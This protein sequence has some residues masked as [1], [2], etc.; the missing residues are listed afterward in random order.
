M[1]LV[2]EQFEQLAR[3]VM[4]SRDVPDSAAVI[5]SGNPESV[6][7]DALVPIAAGVLRESVSR[8]TDR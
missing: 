5:I 3:A 1:I 7:D 2:T 4:R 8:L 6:Q